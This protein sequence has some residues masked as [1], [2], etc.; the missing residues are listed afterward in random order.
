MLH[1]MTTISTII[2]KLAEKKVI[3]G[4]IGVLIIENM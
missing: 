3:L 1:S 2:Y 4:I